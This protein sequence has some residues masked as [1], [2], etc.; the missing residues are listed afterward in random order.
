VNVLIVFDEDN[1]LP[2]LAIIDRNLRQAMRT[3]L[4]DD[5]DFLTMS[6]CSS[7][8]S[9]ARDTTAPC[10]SHFRRKYGRQAARSDRRGLWRRRSTSWPGMARRCFPGVP[11]VFCGAERSDINRKVLRPNVTGNPARTRLC[12]TAR[13]RPALAARHARSPS[14]SAA[15]IG[16]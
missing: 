3:E 12:P 16:L 8:G 15:T 7:R 11:I 1:A 9:R 5:V 10:A 13:G 4:K 14:L 6:R 2:G